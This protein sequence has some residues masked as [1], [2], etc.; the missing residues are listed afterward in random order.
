MKRKIG[1]GHDAWR[2]LLIPGRSPKKVGNKFRGRHVMQE[3]EA[4]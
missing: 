3:E 2:A 4:H 1:T